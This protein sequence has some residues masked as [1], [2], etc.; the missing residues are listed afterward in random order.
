MSNFINEGGGMVNALIVILM[1]VIGIPTIL[2]LL[3]SGFVKLFGV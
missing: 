3:F 1:I 2:G